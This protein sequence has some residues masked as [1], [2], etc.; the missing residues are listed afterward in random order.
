MYSPCSYLMI[1]NIPLNLCDNH[2]LKFDTKEEQFSYF[3]SKKYK[4]YNDYTYLRKDNIIKINENIDSLYNCNYVVYQNQN[5]TNKYFYC[6]IEDLIYI[7]ENVTGVKIKTD[8]YQTW[9]FDITINK[10]FIDRI[11]IA[12]DDYNTINDEVATGELVETKVKN[13]DFTGGY[14]AFCNSDITKDDTSEGSVYD[15]NIDNY[16]IPCWVLFWENTPTGAMDMTKTLQAISNLGRGDRIVSVVYVPIIPDKSKLRLTPITNEEIGDFT[17]CQGVT[18][19]ETIT[20]D[21]DFE[22]TLDGLNFKKQL[23]YPYSKIVVTDKTTG[24]SIE[25]SPEKFSNNVAKFR[26]SCT[27]SETPTYRVIP[28]EY[29]N[30]DQAYRHSLVIKCNTTLPLLNNSYASYLLNE[31]NI[32]KMNMVFSGL[33]GIGS[34]ANK[35]VGGTISSIENIMGIVAQDNKASKQPNQLTNISDSAMDRLCFNNGIKISLYTPDSFHKKL[36]DNFWDMYGYPI[37][38]LNSVTIPNKDH[39]YIKLCDPNISGDIP[40]DDLNEIIKLFENGITIWNTS[41]KFRMY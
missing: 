23:T 20:Q 16:T 12:A 38:T 1:C 31:G 21:I 2:Q 22:I 34:L 40:E 41:E 13:L 24:N 35:N 26:L 27:I 9:Q 32:N 3:L 18:N 29:C 11:T 7:S 10:S 28:L 30:E 36:Q 8:V 33:S 14:F 37:H 39:V 17:L 15:F 4:S 25:L 6:Y 5:F 19:G